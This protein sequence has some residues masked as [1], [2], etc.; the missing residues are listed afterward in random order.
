MSPPVTSI[1][2][3]AI[4]EQLLDYLYEELPDTGRAEVEAHIEGCAR[5]A[6]EVAA[7]RR[8][9]QAARSLPVLEPAPQITTRLLEAAAGRN[10][11]PL[12]LPLRSAHASSPAAAVAGEEG[13]PSRAATEFILAAARAQVTEASVKTPAS[14]GAVPI[15][16]ARRRRRWLSHPGFAAAASFVVVGIGTMWFLST[17]REAMMAPNVALSPSVPP[18][19]ERAEEP[20]PAAALA[21]ETD[22]GVTTKTGA[23]GRGA[24]AAPAAT[25]PLEERKPRGGPFGGELAKEE[26]A[27]RIGSATAMPVAPAPEVASPLA[28]AFA[29]G[30]GSAG[31]GGGGGGGGG[32]ASA[33]DGYLA[34]AAAHGRSTGQPVG[35]PS[36]SPARAPGGMGVNLHADENEALERSVTAA[37]ESAK[38][39]D[40]VGADKRPA[41]DEPAYAEAPP[42]KAAPRDRVWA[43]PPP[44]APAPSVAATTPAT[45]A[46]GPQQRRAEARAD[47]DDALAAE[48]VSPNNQRSRAANKQA[49]LAAFQD[50]KRL[51]C[52]DFLE[53]YRELK[54]AEPT[55]T[56]SARDRMQVAK[57]YGEV[58]QAEQARAE[59]DALRA[60]HPELGPKIDAAQQ[61]QV[62]QNNERDQVAQRKAATEAPAAAA[63][64]K[65]KATRSKAAGKAAADTA[66]T[67]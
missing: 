16:A 11:V 17:N 25:A 54:A 12:P 30:L 29:K 5:C 6:A 40:N 49:P 22:V 27:A 35:K 15:A 64:A 1:D 51:S 53:A 44:P 9:R 31:Q 28:A 41:S 37:R 55:H 60:T 32:A 20:S 47:L 65:A 3:H 14:S 62:S 48:A 21:E 4:D 10:V 42:P 18:E 8:V 36:P 39:R 26:H 38:K 50:A 23:V 61:A 13:Q 19:A 59:Y 45:A 2:C 56:F 58:G 67:Y 24:G 33:G 63:P 7:F 57:C 52:Y 43:A 66:T 46:S 34:G